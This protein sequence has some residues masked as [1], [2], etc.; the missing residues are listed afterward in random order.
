[1][2]PTTITGTGKRVDDDLPSVYVARR[3]ADNVRKTSESGNSMHDNTPRCI[4]AR[5]R[6][7]SRVERC[8][9]KRKFPPMEETGTARRGMKA[10]HGRP[11]S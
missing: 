2:F 8:W 7:D 10:A 9:G 4:Q 3:M 11:D 1:M 6:A 5:I